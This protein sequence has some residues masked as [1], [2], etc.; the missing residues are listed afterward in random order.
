MKGRKIMEKCQKHTYLLLIWILGTEDACRLCNPNVPGSNLQEKEEQRQGRRRK[1][2]DD[3]HNP[4]A[5][6]TGYN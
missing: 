2:A 1:K 6:Q 5:K 4:E 3:S